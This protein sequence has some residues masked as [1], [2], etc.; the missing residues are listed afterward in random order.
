MS[1]LILDAM[2][3]HHVQNVIIAV[4]QPK[5]GSK[6]TIQLCQDDQGDSDCWKFVFNIDN[7]NRIIYGGMTITQKKFDENAWK[8][9]QK[10]LELRLT[11]RSIGLFHQ[12]VEI[13]FHQS[14]AE[15]PIMRHDLN[16][17]LVANDGQGGA[18]FTVNS[19]S[20]RHNKNEVSLLDRK[21]QVQNDHTDAFLQ[22]MVV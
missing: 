3:A 15:Y 17:L 10:A 8:N 4:A 18:R 2:N 9:W 22:D 14:N 21:I 5:V 11:D 20:Y 19:V 13:L 6:T 16:S 12:G 7:Q 1:V